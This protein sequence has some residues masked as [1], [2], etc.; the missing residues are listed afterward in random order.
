[1]VLMA[2]AGIKTVRLGSKE[3]A[4]NP[5]RFDDALFSTFDLFHEAYPDVRLELV[6]HYV[7]PFELVQPRIN[8]Q[9]HYLYDV[10][11]PYVVHPDLQEALAKLNSRRSWFGH[12]NQFPVIAGVNDKPEIMRLLLHLTNKLGINMHNVYAC[13]E[14][15]GNPHFRGDLTI[16]RQYDL[17]EKA[18][19]GLS[20]LE[21]HA[22][23]IMSTEQGKMDVMGHKDGKVILRL[24]R[25]LHG[26]KPENTMI[27][28]D[29][30]KIDNDA[31]G[32]FYWLTQEVI[33]T[34]VD[35][36][37]RKMLNV[38]YEVDTEFI[39]GVKAAAAA[40]V[41]HDQQQPQAAA[42]EV[43]LAAATVEDPVVVTAAVE[44]PIVVRKEATIEVEGADGNNV[45]VLAIKHVPK[46]GES[47]AHILEANG[48]VEMVCGGQLSC[49]TCVG[50]V[51]SDQPLASPSLD[52]MDA[53]DTVDN[54]NNVNLRACCQ[55]KA[56]PGVSYTFKS[57]LE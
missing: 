42:E 26:R 4:F 29:S 38:N 3:L 43:T 45:S 12:H 40:E 23:L 15:I 47:L 50:E 37:S 52:E 28:V 14:V 20:G 57:A 44:D 19:V 2:E 36:Q 5:A 39:K 35:E 55:I 41:F 18:K 56:V 24:N 11:E 6:G 16:D 30:A 8:A 46:D 27:I 31:G 53:T 22:R 9:G 32:K 13:R 7:H 34:A 10:S 49:T 51:T 1:M 25:F 33:D 17:L 48:H 54:P 21:N